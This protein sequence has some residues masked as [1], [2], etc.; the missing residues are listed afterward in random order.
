ML[1]IVLTKVVCY[2]SKQEKEIRYFREPEKEDIDNSKNITME[3]FCQLNDKT[4]LYDNKYYVI[5]DTNLIYHRHHFCGCTCVQFHRFYCCKHVLALSRLL[6]L[7]L[8]GYTYGDFFAIK[9]KPGK[10]KARN[11]L[12]YD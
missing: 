3:S 11:C 5:F 8:K 10:K 9:T 4:Y 6:K 12:S 2:H 1:K 7:R